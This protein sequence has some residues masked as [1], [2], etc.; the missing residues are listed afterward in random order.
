M[1]QM[2]GGVWRREDRGFPTVA[3]AFQR[4]PTTF[5]GRIAP[6]GAFPPEAGRY[7]LYISLACPWAH[8]TLI[9]RALK[10]LEEIILSLKKEERVILRSSNCCSP[11]NEKMVD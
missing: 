1:G 3:G 8:R 9:V 10:K 4:A 5:H 7:H 2:V 11:S 6:G